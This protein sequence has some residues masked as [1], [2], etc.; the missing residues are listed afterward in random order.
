MK[1][2]LRKIRLIDSFSTEIEIEK[3]V[4]VKRFKD[5]VDEGSTGIMFSAFEA[6]SSGKNEFK[7]S[8][9]FEGFQVRRKRKLFEMNSGMAVATGNYHQKD[10]ILVIETEVNGF[11]GVFVLFYIMG[12]LMYPIFFVTTF[13]SDEPFPLF[14]I[15]FLFIH[16]AFWF[17]IPYLA[18]RRSTQRMKYEL[19]REFFY[20]TKK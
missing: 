12:L 6:F 17:G 2:F 5:H 9:S 8:V 18:M 19:E 11:H 13:L 3:A 14:V 15:P 1:D 16:A 7:G 20:M 10:N 4:F